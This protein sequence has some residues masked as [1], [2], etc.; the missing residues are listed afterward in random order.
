MVAF[1]LPA[2]AS[3]E[4]ELP[5]QLAAAGQVARGADGGARS[6]APAA[7]NAREKNSAQIGAAG[8][9]EVRGARRLSP[10]KIAARR[11]QKG[12]GMRGAALACLVAGAAAQSDDN[13]PD[14][15][16]DAKLAGGLGW[17]ECLEVRVVLTYNSEHPA[18]VDY[19]DPTGHYGE[20]C[21]LSSHF[22]GETVTTPQDCPIG[23]NC[24]EMADRNLGVQA[25]RNGLYCHP[26]GA[27]EAGHV[28]VCEQCAGCN[29]ANCGNC[30]TKFYPQVDQYSVLRL[31]DY[32]DSLPEAASGDQVACADTMGCMW[33][34]TNCRPGP[35]PAAGNSG[36][37]LTLRAS[38]DTKPDKHVTFSAGQEF[39]LETGQEGVGNGVVRSPV[40]AFSNDDQS[41]V[42][43]M[44]AKI[45]LLNGFPRLFTWE[46]TGVINSACSPKVNR[47]GSMNTIRNITAGCTSAGGACEGNA[48]CDDTARQW[49][50]TDCGF[51]T[52]T[53]YYADGK[54]AGMQWPGPSCTGTAT[55]TSAT[56]DCSAVAP[57]ADLTCP[58]GC[59][60]DAGTDTDVHPQADADCSQSMCAVEAPAAADLQSGDVRCNS[61]FIIHPRS[62]LTLLCLHKQEVLSPFNIYL[63]WTGTDKDARD[64]SSQ[65]LSYESF[66]QYSAFE[67]IAAARDVAREVAEKS[68]RCVTSKDC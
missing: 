42:I 19:V 4:R 31:L 10:L 47:P 61:P 58:A 16:M 48:C 68:R 34:G 33:T 41:Y 35:T 67:A 55:D 5:H 62:V 51:S 11:A 20:D 21:V 44:Y 26:G 53:G 37:H 8:R 43:A 36:Q 18:H 1:I 2:A 27:T 54:F 46:Q 45:G 39:F 40:V 22:T 6:G 56:P 57:S 32:C 17:N 66:R 3:A 28:G 29:G 9:G 64:M 60:Y 7:C 25:C 49:D 30:K 50:M 65:G 59:T 15:N 52:Y 24:H 14:A 13:C 38:T 12:L 23:W 63:T